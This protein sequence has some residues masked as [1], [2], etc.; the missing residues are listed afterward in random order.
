VPISTASEM[1][2]T[3]EWRNSLIKYINGVS[4]PQAV[5]GALAAG[6]F[7]AQPVLN[8]IFAVIEPLYPGADTEYF[9]KHLV[10]EAEHVK[11]ITTTIARLVDRSH[12]FE[13]VVAGYKF[14]LSVWE[15]FFS[16]L[17]E[18]IAEK[19]VVR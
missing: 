9:T 4:S 16:H 18:Y 3:V 19:Q 11:E 2:F 8:K 15:S 1:A 10:L 7:L 5:L 12:Q 17:T 14:G 6:E 13:E